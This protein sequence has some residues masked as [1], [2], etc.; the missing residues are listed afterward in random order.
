MYHP[1]K[2]PDCKDCESKMNKISRAYDI[3]SNPD[4]K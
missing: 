2:N 3:L 4:S 1:D